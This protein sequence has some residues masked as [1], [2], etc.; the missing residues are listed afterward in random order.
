MVY[1]VRK[2]SDTMGNKKIRPAVQADL[3]QIEKIYAQAR[4]FMAENGNPTQWGND[5]PRRE[6]LEADIKAGN[7]YVAEDHDQIY[8]VF[9]F[10]I[11]E[12]PTY[13]YIENG[14][15]CSDLPYGTQ[16]KTRMDADRWRGRQEK[17]ISSEN[18]WMP[19]R[20]TV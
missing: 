17:E 5:Y 14:G 8:G 7:L 10:V 19:A 20:N 2:G 18:F 16:R 9:L 11:G 1:N 4:R 12:D 15:W 6:L 3:N 13:S